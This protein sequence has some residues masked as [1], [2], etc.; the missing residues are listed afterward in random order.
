[1]EGIQTADYDRML[2]LQDSGFTCVVGCAMG[3][4]AA[5]DKYASAKKVRFDVDLVVQHH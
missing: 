2:K 3:Y 4:R 5:D 1:M